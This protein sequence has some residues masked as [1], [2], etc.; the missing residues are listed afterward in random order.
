MGDYFR[1]GIPP[2]T[3]NFSVGI[4]GFPTLKE[5]PILNF[6]RLNFTITLVNTNA[7]AKVYDLASS[8]LSSTALELDRIRVLGIRG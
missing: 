5:T 2:N 1:V 4:G 3:Y 6:S 8:V 7:K